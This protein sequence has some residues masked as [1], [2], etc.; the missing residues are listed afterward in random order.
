MK[1]SKLTIAAYAQDLAQ[2]EQLLAEGA[3][4]DGSENEVWHGDSTDCLNGAPYYTPL[5]EACR[6][7]SSPREDG[8]VEEQLQVISSL[9]AAGAQV[10]LRNYRNETAF[11]FACQ[12]GRAEV[13]RLIADAGANLAAVGCLGNGINA[14]INSYSPDKPG[15]VKV[16]GLCALIALGV[17]PHP[18]NAWGQ[19][20][21]E[22]AGDYSGNLT[23]R[24]RSEKLSGRAKLELM[25]LLGEHHSDWTELQEWLKLHRAANLKGDAK[26]RKAQERIAKLRSQ[27]EEPG[28]EKKV[29]RAIGKTATGKFDQLR[30][31]TKGLLIDPAVVAHESWSRLLRHLLSLTASYSDVTE[32]TYGERLDIEQMD[33][34]EGSAL[35]FYGD[36][37]LSTIEHCLMACRAPGAGDR[38]DFAN[39]VREI[40][41]TKFRQIGHMSYGDQE[42]VA[43]IQQLNEIQHAD[44]DELRTIAHKCFPH[45]AW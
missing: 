11:H 24:S 13:I 22:K 12:V 45:A 20:L 28:F 9:L 5:G 2:V 14:L 15:G 26:Q 32:D 17:D 6:N 4:P 40:C 43:L 35:D 38:S 33:Q 23:S 37:Q 18:L 42:A 16:K 31:L 30:G 41:E 29:L 10:D 44:I 7:S 27:T 34:D 25:E 21:V 1:K 36:E 19:G 39:L 3:C 8:T